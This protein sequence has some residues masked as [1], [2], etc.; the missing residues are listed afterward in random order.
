MISIG[1]L[2]SLF[3]IGADIVDENA[4]VFVLGP[5]PEFCLKKYL[6]FR[7]DIPGTC[8][9]RSNQLLE[10][11]GDNIQQGMLYWESFCP[12]GALMFFVL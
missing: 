11:S 5:E 3:G 12:E 9:L 2:N 4:S 10:Q 7:L 1:E 6:F 8:H